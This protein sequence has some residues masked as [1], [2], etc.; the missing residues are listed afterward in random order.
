VNQRKHLIRLVHIG[1][2]RLGMDDE[3][4]RAMQLRI[5][6]QASCADMDEPRLR[7]VI[8][9][10]NRMGAKLAL[11]EP[12]TAG[13][14]RAPL[15]AKLQAIMHADGHTEGY[16]LGIS[17]RMY[18]DHAPAELKWHSPKQ[19]RALIAALMYYRKRRA[20]A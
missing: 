17:R 11:P 8:R 20:H 13:T 6:G 2:S 7:A 19:L 14:D 5:T 3:T 15:L 9:E 12:H 16:V 10:L 4:R 18:G 1:A